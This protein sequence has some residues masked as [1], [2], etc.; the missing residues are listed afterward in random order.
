MSLRRA[1]VASIVAAL[2]GAPLARAATVVHSVSCPAEQTAQMDKADYE[3][4][5]APYKL[6]IDPLP[7]GTKERALPIPRFHRMAEHD[8]D[9]PLSVRA[10]A[11]LLQNEEGKVDKVLVPCASS[12]KAIEPIVA[13]M[14]RARLAKATRNGAPSKALVV[15]PVEWGL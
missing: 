1:L 11:V 4:E 14:S 2:C 12:A 3:R 9:F 13:A 8:R 6:E 5:V 7:P 15:V 10:P